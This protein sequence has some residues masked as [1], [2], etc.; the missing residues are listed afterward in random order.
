MYREQDNIKEL[1]NI[2][3]EIQYRLKKKID[4]ETS[5]KTEDYM[6][7]YDQ[8]AK[9]EKATDKFKREQ[10]SE[11]VKEVIDYL[12]EKKNRK[13]HRSRSR[14]GHRHKSRDRSERSRRSS[15]SRRSKQQ[16]H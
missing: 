13:R 4:I 7:L 11:I 15:G 8:I 10:A 16:S 9:D 6:D 2:K 1:Q 14:S 5:V 3:D 12:V